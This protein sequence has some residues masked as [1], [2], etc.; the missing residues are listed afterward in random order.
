[1][2][3]AEFTE[4]FQDLVARKR[5]DFD[6][7]NRL[8]RVCDSILGCKNQNILRG[9]YTRWKRLPESPVKYRHI[10]TLRQSIRGTKWKRG[11]AN[12]IW[13]ETFGEVEVP[14]FLRDSVG[15]QLTL[16][17]TDRQESAENNGSETVTKQFGNSSETDVND[18]ACLNRSRTV[19]EPYRSQ[20]RSQ[21]RSQRGANCFPG[22]LAE[23][24]WALQEEYR[25]EVK[26]AP[27]TATAAD[28]ERVES[29]LEEAGFTEA[30]AEAA[31]RSYRDQ[32]RRDITKARY[33]NGRINWDPRNIQV[34][35]AMGSP[36]NGAP[37]SPDLTQEALQAASE[38][39]IP[40]EDVEA[41]RAAFED[42]PGHG[43]NEGTS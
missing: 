4:S 1:M 34:A 25:A 7:P 33:F 9:W 21:I 42:P 40:A 19:R 20:I 32:V 2:P 11:S 39:A 22:T 37:A 27:L 8:L 5:F 6:G 30:H 29:C 35:A 13:S 14:D 36:G 10:A 15:P 23:R 38:P 12:Q 31:L 18:S 24:L 17:G 41:F 16:I 28:L 3:L 43:S 26:L